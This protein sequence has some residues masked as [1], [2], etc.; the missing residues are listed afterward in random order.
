MKNHLAVLREYA[1]QGQLQ[2]LVWYPDNFVHML[3]RP[4]FVYTGNPDIDS[5]LNFKLGQA[6]EAEGR[7]ELDVKLPEDFNANT[8]DLAVFTVG[9]SSIWRNSTSSERVQRQL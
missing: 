7:L 5:I 6:E 9:L 2:E 1:A 8:F 4:G 3:L